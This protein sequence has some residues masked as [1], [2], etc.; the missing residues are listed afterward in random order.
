M[1]KYDHLF[2]IQAVF[3]NSIYIQSVQLSARYIRAATQT[4]VIDFFKQ[5]Y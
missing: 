5:K 4:I 3:Q 1:G 2:K